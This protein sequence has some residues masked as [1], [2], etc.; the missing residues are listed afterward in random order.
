VTAL[1]SLMSYP[2]RERP[3]QGCTIRRVPRKG[4]LRAAQQLRA[5]QGSGWSSSRPIWAVWDRREMHPKPADQGTHSAASDAPLA[6]DMGYPEHQYRFGM[7]P[8]DPP[9]K[10]PVRLGVLRAAA[11][12]LIGRQMG[13]AA[14]EDDK[15]QAVFLTE[16]AKELEHL[17]LRLAKSD[18]NDPSAIAQLQTL[19]GR[20]EKDL[21]R[22]AAQIRMY[23]LHHEDRVDHVA[24]KNLLAAA[25][26]GALEPLTD[27]QDEWFSLLEHFDQMPE[28]ES[29][30]QLVTL[31]PALREF[32]QTVLRA[33]LDLWPSP[34]DPDDAI[35][36]FVVDGLRRLV[37]PE[38][39]TEDSV[40]KT[41]LAYGTCRV[42][43]LRKVGVP[44]SD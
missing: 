30:E 20:H 32:E 22:A 18:P 33:A 36:G 12:A 9:A 31:Q 39:E 3:G 29:F 23:G 17:A 25:T 26:G 4:R 44:L 11:M 16:R 8:E 14:I 27:E 34:L 19:A 15:P 10:V 2:H 21:R 28:S 5:G 42:H 35:I 24:N 13:E 43:L 37:G 40:V 38:A 7:E 1:Q 41:R 6:G